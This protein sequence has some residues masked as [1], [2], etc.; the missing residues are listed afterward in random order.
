[1]N[2]RVASN[3]SRKKIYTG[4]GKTGSPFFSNFHIFER[5][6]M[7]K[8]RQKVISIPPISFSFAFII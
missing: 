4:G 1:M 8:K 5:L 7:T 2:I 3:P 6:F